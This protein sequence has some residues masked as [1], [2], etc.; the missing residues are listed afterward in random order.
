MG[1]LM[2][3]L[4]IIAGLLVGWVERL[5]YFDWL[6][7]LAVGGFELVWW[8][9]RG[10]GL[11]GLAALALIGIGHVSLPAL[12]DRCGDDDPVC[13]VTRDWGR[14]F[15]DVLKD[16]PPASSGPQFW[17]YQGKSYWIVVR[18][19][20]DRTTFVDAKNN[21]VEQVCQHL[22]AA[23]AVQK[24]GQYL[25]PQPIGLFDS[26]LWPEVVIRCHVEGGATTYQFPTLGEKGVVAK[27]GLIA[28][29]Q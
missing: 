13:F 3:W 16:H 21:S 5:F 17:S 22:Y 9:L 25:K 7:S 29:A 20:T 14:S 2:V 11:L 1:R 15:L 4:G 27:D 19:T 23:H 24:D 12:S 6:A 8:L 26:I 18:T 10:V 28:N